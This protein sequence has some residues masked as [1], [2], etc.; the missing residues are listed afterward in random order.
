MDRHCENALKLAKYLE[1]HKEIDAVKY[2][3]LPSHQNYETAKKQMKLGGGIVTFVV[4]GG[5]ERGRNF[6]NSLQMLSLTANL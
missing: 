3:F 1:S 6:L 5:L 4:K 2:P